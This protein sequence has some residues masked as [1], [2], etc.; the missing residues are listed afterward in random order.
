MTELS[1][2]L[3][4]VTGFLLRLH[5]FLIVLSGITACAAAAGWTPLSL[6]ERMGTLFTDQRFLLVGF[7]VLPLIGVLEQ[8][9]LREHAATWIRQRR[10]KAGQ[11][12]GLYLAGRQGTAA[13]GL[14]TL[15]GHPQTV[16]PLLVPMVLA[17]RPQATAEERMQ[18]K[19]LSAATD[20][21]ALFF[22]EDVFFAFGAVLLMQSFLAAQGYVLD[23][24]AIALWGIP[25]AL[26]ALLIH[27][28]RV[29]RIDR[30]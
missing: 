18:L 2:L 8:K 24:L 17:L 12:L 21:V 22:G 6:F 14:T 4:I 29:L 7:L 25:T 20:N 3:V 5:P 27:G 13:V 16:R 1:P 23:P 30:S 11:L 10:L 28:W 26:C 15:G 19:S 9:G